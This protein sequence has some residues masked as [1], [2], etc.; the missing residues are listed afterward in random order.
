MIYNYVQP[1]GGSITAHKYSI[2]T[3][4]LRLRKVQ[5]MNNFFKEVGYPFPRSY[6]TYCKLNYLSLLKEKKQTKENTNS[7]IY[8]IKINIFYEF[9]KLAKRAFAKALKIISK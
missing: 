1:K 7:S 6:F 2:Q 3:Y 9:Y 8:Q 5:W 4:G